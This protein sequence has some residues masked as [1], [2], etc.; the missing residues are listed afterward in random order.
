MNLLSSSLT[1]LLAFF[2]LYMRYFGYPCLFRIALCLLWGFGDRLNQET[3]GA[4][5]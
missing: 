2:Y 4:S 3:Q 1:S 5:I